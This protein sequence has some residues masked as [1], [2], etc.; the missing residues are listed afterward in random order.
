MAKP[1]VAVFG[2]SQTRSGEPAWDDALRLGTLLG[3][4]GFDV[5]TGG[6]GGVMEAVS[7]GAANA[8]ARVV[9]VTAPPLFPQ[10][11]GPNPFV[12]EEHPA[13]TLAGRINEMLHLADAAIT[14]PGSIGTLT[15][16]MVAWN[17]LFIRAMANQPQFPV[18][19]VGPTWAELVPH[20]ARVLET[21]PSLVALAGDVEEA[22]RLVRERVR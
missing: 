6:Y 13:N 15:E 18:V 21:D 19:A 2:S 9:G 14:M 20:I 1:I 22:A 10:R 3:T 17:E 11:P 4:Y 12:T 7:E 16:L 5:A 8:G